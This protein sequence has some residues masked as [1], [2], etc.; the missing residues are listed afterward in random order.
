MAPVRS[1]GRR[2]GRPGS[3]ARWAVR[4]AP[5]RRARYSE[6][7]T[8]RA[9]ARRPRRGL[10]G[11]AARPARSAASRP[12]LAP[13]RP[14]SVRDLAERHVRL[15]ARADAGQE[16]LGTGR[17]IGQALDRLVGHGLVASG[18]DGAS[19]LDLAPLRLRIDALRFWLLR[20]TFPK[21]VDP[22]HDLLALL[23]GTLRGVGGIRDL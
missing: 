19:P 16:V 12:V 21:G 7:S 10:S 1:P 22:N 4:S 20:R 18:A 17:R 11:L 9:S 15:H 2:R 13:H 6:A 3:A 23:N 14:Q 5:G 8:L